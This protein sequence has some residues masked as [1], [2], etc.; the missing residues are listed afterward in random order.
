MFELILGARAVVSAVDNSHPRA[1]WLPV[2]AAEV[3]QHLAAVALHVRLVGQDP[4]SVHP[5]THR[6]HLCEERVRSEGEADELGEDVRPDGLDPGGGEAE[7]ERGEG[8][9]R[10]GHGGEADWPRPLLSRSLS[11]C[12]GEGR[13]LDTHRDPTHCCPHCSG[14]RSTVPGLV[15]TLAT[16]IMI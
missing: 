13:N 7:D 10:C 8:G 2:L 15:T 11:L 1:G 9:V 16:A 5:S 12:C 4:R 3:P 6:G 14:Q